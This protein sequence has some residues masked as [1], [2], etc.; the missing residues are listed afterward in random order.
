MCLD[1]QFSSYALL[2]MWSME[3]PT[4]PSTKGQKPKSNDTKGAPVLQQD[5]GRPTDMAVGSCVTLCS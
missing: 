1:E 5:K 3:T 2:R 4:S